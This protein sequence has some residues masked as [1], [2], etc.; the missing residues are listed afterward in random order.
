MATP[1]QTGGFN[2]AAYGQ[3]RKEGAAEQAERAVPAFDKLPHAVWRTITFPISERS[4]RFAHEGT[5][6]QFIYR[7]GVAVEMMG[8]GPRVFTYTVPFRDGVT[9]GPYGN[10]GAD[11]TPALFSAWLLKFWNSYYSDKSPGPL[12]DPVYGDL[13]CVPQEWDETSDAQ[14][15]DGVTVRVSFKEHTPPDGEAPRL[16]NTLDQIKAGAVRLDDEVDR[17]DWKVQE[18]SPN[19][20]ND[21][22]ST[23]A[24]VIQKGNY[25][26]NRAK[27]RI[28]GVVER[29]RRVEDAAAEAEKTATSGAGFLREQARILRL[30]TLR[31]TS[32]AVVGGRRVRTKARNSDSTVIN[33][34]AKAGMTI[35]EFLNLNP[36]LAGSLIIK[37]GTIFKVY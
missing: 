15:R 27:G 23:I 25:Q 7:D 16:D 4:V 12:Y 10:V 8:A 18:D 34:A 37:R 3:S 24:G 35:E 9:K 2:S 31:L 28:Q 22:F 11:S 13:I 14:A 19:A 29:I 26:M 1:K 21:L 36:E 20:Q 32:S 33:E 5:D 30:K 17:I 6:H